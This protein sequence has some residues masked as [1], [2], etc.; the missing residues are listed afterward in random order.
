MRNFHLALAL[1]GI[2]G[3]SG[4]DEDSSAAADFA[5][6]EG[7]WNWSGAT[8]TLDECSLESAFPPAILDAL[9]WSVTLQDGGFAVQQDAFVPLDC[10][11]DG[12]DFS[13]PA[14]LETDVTEWPAGS[15]QTGD[16]DVTNYT[17]GT[18]AGTFSDAET[19]SI[20][21]SPT[22]TCEGADCDAYGA[23]VGAPSPCDSVI[24]GN[25]M[26]NQG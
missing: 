3:C 1:V 8:Y 15:S 5:P 17:N 26:L 13:C 2:I 9:E 18:V 20:I 19:A 11:L 6:T 12:M 22:V 25:F 16:P 14:T 24:E 7:I 23:E 21:F 4:K 10:T